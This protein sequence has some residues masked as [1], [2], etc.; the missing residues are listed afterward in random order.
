MVL[1]TMN[2]PRKHKKV[3]FH[4]NFLLDMDYV[5]LIWI[6]ANLSFISNILCI[7]DKL[8]RSGLPI[9]VNVLAT[10]L[11]ASS[12]QER[13]IRLIHCPSINSNNQGQNPYSCS[14]NSYTS[15]CC[16]FFASDSSAFDMLICF[17][18]VSC[19]TTLSI[20][21][22]CN[23]DHPVNFIKVNCIEIRVS[24]VSIVLECWTELNLEPQLTMKVWKCVLNSWLILGVVDF[25]V[26]IY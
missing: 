13:I 3:R 21:F 14:S 2:F 26:K 22:W 8:H 5:C 6:L 10:L 18:T 19:A 17:Y 25:F 20:F 23:C 11:D 16:F 24:V 9:D 4:I 7:T 1:T 15:F 12:I